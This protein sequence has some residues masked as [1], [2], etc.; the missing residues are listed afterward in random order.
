MRQTKRCRDRIAAFCRS[1]D[2]TL[3][4]VIIRRFSPGFKTNESY[5]YARACREWNIGKVR[6]TREEAAR[7]MVRERTGGTRRLRVAGSLRVARGT[8]KRVAGGPEGD[9]RGWRVAEGKGKGRQGGPLFL[10]TILRLPRTHLL[11]VNQDTDAPP[12]A[13]GIVYVSAVYASSSTLEQ[14]RRTH[15]SC[16]VHLCIREFIRVYALYIRRR[17]NETETKR[18]QM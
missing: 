2:L 13:R 5:V 11:S 17:E 16:V 9:Q 8:C 12:S 7:G 15:S 10:P 18:L 3:A 4:R 6:K 1:C 14:R